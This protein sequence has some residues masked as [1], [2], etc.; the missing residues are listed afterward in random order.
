MAAGALG[1]VLELF[2]GPEAPGPWAPPAMPAAL[3]ALLPW[4]A[5]DEASELYVNAG[6]TGFAIELPPF[7][8]I[9][10]E[11]LGA[12]A[13]TL[14]DA[15][16]ERCTVQVIHWASPRFGAA[17]RAWA[18]PRTASGGA[19]A[20]MGAR[21]SELLAPG[22][23]RRLH[24]GGPPFTLADY[25]VLVTACLAGGTARSATPG[26]AAE[27]ALGAFRRALE[28]TLASAGARTRRLEPD[29]LLSL[30]AELTA[31]DIGGY[32]DGETERPARR[33][34]PRDP[35]HEQCIAPGRALSVAPTGLTFHHGG[36]LQSGGTD[37]SPARVSPDGEDPGAADIAVRV[38]SAVT[39][40][41]VWPGWRGNALIGDFHRDFLQPGCP[42]LDLPDRG[43]RRRGGG[44]EGVSE[45]RAR[46]PAGRYRNRPLPP[47]PARESQGLAGGHR[48]DQG[49]RAAGPRLLHGRG[50]R[51]A[52]RARRG[53][54]GGARDLSRPG[55]AGERRALRPAPLLARLPPHGLGR[56]PRRR[57]RANGPDEDPAHVERGQPQP[58]ARR[59]AGPTR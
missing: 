52:R 7:A 28:G 51:A 14:A 8:G 10:A 48:A 5:W 43:H 3:H 38:L 18:E 58:P 31:P 26:P 21:R 39:F 32:R 50:L 6:S 59:V 1:R 33:W 20:R 40:P 11:T 17:S 57:S 9:D 35:L 24:A 34:A 27:T 12:L 16:P 22:G 37:R 56:R 25:R 29:G 45:V 49:R 19:L 36:T 55:L 2:E 54:T 46:D 15:A 13:G 47:R 53:R 23:W 4:R 41:E 42:V 44:R 30:A